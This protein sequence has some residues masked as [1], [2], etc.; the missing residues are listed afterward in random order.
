MAALS[1]VAK[2]KQLLQVTDP[3]DDALLERLL[4]AASAWIATQCGYPSTGMLSA[5][6]TFTFSGEDTRGWS[7]PVQP[8]TGITSVTIDG[9]ALPPRETDVDGYYLSD[10]GRV[11]LSGGYR[12]TRGQ[13]NCVV[14]ATCGFPAEAVPA[15]LEAA[16]LTLA[17]QRFQERNRIGQVSGNVG[18]VQVTW[19]TFSAP[20]DVNLTIQAYRL[21]SF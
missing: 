20:A 11:E 5:E 12:F 14:V 19:S 15:D 2:L 4:D 13:G 6:Q 3:A 18:G 7:L 21:G 1:T 8:V 9:E 10:F 16:A 17:A